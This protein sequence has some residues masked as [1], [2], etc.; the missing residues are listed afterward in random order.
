M[1][2]GLGSLALLALSVPGSL[3]FEYYTFDGEGFPSCYDVSAVFN[4]SSVDNIVSLVQEAI[5]N[6]TNVRGAGKGRKYFPAL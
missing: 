4:A 5:Q 2:L 3:G 6:G 1:H